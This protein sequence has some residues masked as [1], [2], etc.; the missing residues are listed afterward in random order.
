MNW[1]SLVVKELTRLVNGRTQVSVS[2]LG[3][4]VRSSAGK[5]KDPGSV[6]SGKA[7]GW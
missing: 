3:L 5:P 6:S 2:R 4:V 1:L 7:L